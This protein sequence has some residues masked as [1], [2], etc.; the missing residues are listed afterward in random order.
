M[1]V[2][3]LLV[4][5]LFPLQATSARIELKRFDSREC[6]ADFQLIMRTDNDAH[7]EDCPFHTRNL[8]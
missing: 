5:F 7:G 1:P 6:M 3:V 2:S 4:F 8:P